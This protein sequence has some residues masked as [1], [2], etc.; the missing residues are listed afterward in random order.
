MK[1]YGRKEIHDKKNV[2]IF[3]QR[4]ILLFV[5][6]FSLSNLVLAEHSLPVYKP[7]RNNIPAFRQEIVFFTT[8]TDGQLSPFSTIDY[9][10]RKPFAET[11]VSILSLQTKPMHAPAEDDP[12]FPPDPGQLPIGDGIG[13]LLCLSLLYAFIRKSSYLFTHYKQEV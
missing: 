3:F 5:I 9:T 7:Q 6:S 12:P 4:I 11:N 2:F 1:I 10:K 8:K 13:F